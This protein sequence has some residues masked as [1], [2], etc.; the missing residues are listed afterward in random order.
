MALLAFLLAALFGGI[1]GYYGLPAE[2]SY[3]LAIAAVLTA[4]R[5]ASDWPGGEP[6]TG[7]T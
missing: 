5:I 1:S 6:P 2:G 4:L 7:T 3:L